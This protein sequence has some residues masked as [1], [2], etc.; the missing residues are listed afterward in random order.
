MDKN[1]N[2]CYEKRDFY[3]KKRFL[4]IL[5]EKSFFFRMK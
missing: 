4:D 1:P 3:I 5:P 2:S